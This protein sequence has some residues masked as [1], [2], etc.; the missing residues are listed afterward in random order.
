LAQVAALTSVLCAGCESAA[1][2]A[3]AP[4]EEQEQS[5]V[6]GK[7]ARASAYPWMVALFE[8]YKS[9]PYFMCGGTL[10][11]STHVLTAG[12][13]SLSTRMDDEKH[14]FVTAP[15]EPAQVVVAQRPQ[16]LAG[17]EGEDVLEVRN[18]IVHPQFGGWNP[19]YDVAVWELAKPVDLPEYPR[20]MKHPAVQELLSALH[21]PA[22]VLGYGQLG[23]EDE[24][25]S[26]KL[27]QV[28]VPLVSREQCRRLHVDDFGGG[29]PPE[30]VITDQMICAGYRAGGKDA[31]YGD[32]GGPLLLPTPGKPPLLAGVVSWGNG[33]AEPNSPGVYA[34]VSVMSD[35]ISACQEGRCETY[36]PERDCD[37]GYHDCDGDFDG[38]GCEVLSM[39]P[40]ACGWA[41][42]GAPACGE[43]EA[44]IFAEEPYCTPAKPIIPSTY[45]VVKEPD[46]YGDYLAIFSLLNENEGSVQVP[47]ADQQF[48]DGAEWILIVDVIPPTF[49]QGAAIVLLDRPDAGTYT[50][51][52]PDGVERTTSITADTPD[53]RDLEEEEEEEP[54]QKRLARLANEPGRRVNDSLRSRLAGLGLHAK[55]TPARRAARP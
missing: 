52:G 24:E 25:G 44:C 43:K 33:C 42:C 17:L 47:V 39:S 12:H 31:C 26:D 18:V 38:T 22:R 14:Q 40:A 8:L 32:S 13:C 54:M 36:A 49:V 41:A 15:T 6:G 46:E 55:Q 34:N 27:M 35:Y 21:T 16:S 53:C 10:I 11:D 9:K 2:A 1:P 29:V 50:V 28:D 30:E 5:I 7:A 23:E 3:R 19:T 4:L 45:C 37:W 51:R 48:S 20:L